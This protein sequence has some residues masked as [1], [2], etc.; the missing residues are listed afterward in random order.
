MFQLFIWDGFGH[1]QVELL[2]EKSN[3][4]KKVARNYTAS[5]RNEIYS[6]SRSLTATSKTTQEQCISFFL[7]E[8]RTSRE[9]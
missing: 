5:R 3:N 9:K 8:K 7:V 1:T 2:K 4:L 6:N